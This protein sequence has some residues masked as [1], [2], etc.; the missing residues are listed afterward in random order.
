MSTELAR[1]AQYVNT[2]GVVCLFVRK[3]R[4]FFLL[5]FLEVQHFP[6]VKDGAKR[7]SC[8]LISKCD[9]TSLSCLYKD[10]AEVLK[11]ALCTVKTRRHKAGDGVC[12]VTVEKA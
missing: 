5:L 6:A 10:R 7:Q 2:S 11:G 1:N 12:L 9:I 8:T 4:K 3:N